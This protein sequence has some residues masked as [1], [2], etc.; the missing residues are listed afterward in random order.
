MVKVITPERVYY[1]KDEV[2]LSEINELRLTTMAEMVLDA[3]T[4]D[5]L[6]SRD[7]DLLKS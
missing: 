6:K 4:F 5:V 1:I 3:N 2:M 7:P